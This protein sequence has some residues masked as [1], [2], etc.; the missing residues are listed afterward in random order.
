MKRAALLSLAFLLALPALH[1]A[2]LPDATPEQL[3]RW[4]GFN[5]LEKFVWRGQREKFREDDFRM[6]AGWGFNFVRLPMDYRGWIVDG[7]WNRIDDEALRDI[8]EAVTFGKKYG[9]HVCLNFHRAPGYCV[10][11]PAEPQSLW[12]NDAALA[13]CAKHW[14][15]FAKRYKGVPSRQLSFNLM[16]EPNDKVTCEK[17][18]DVVKTI[19]DAIR[20]ED[21]DRLV[22]VDAP[23][24]GRTPCPQLAELR[25]AQATRGYAPMAV[26]HYQ[27]NWIHGS[28]N[29][30]PPAW[31]TQD[32][33]GELY[34]AWKKDL[35]APLAITGALSRAKVRLTVAEV[36]S[37]A[38]FEL[39]ANGKPVWQRSF[40]PNKG[41]ADAVK[42]DDRKG[43]K[44][45]TYNRDYAVELPDGTDRIELR[46]AGGDWM[47]LSSIGIA[48][49]GG[50]EVVLGLRSQWGK[51]NA[52]IGFDGRA[53]QA[54]VSEDASTLWRNGIEPWLTLQ[55]D[56]QVGVMVGEWGAFNRTP[57][58]VTLRWM[59]DCL[60]NWERA[61]WGWAVW[62]FRG[63]FGPL[64]SGRKDVAYEE[65][66]GHQ[67]DRR[68]LE[69]LRQH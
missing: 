15:H 4:R 34:G 61:G 6:I 5:L 38:D 68:M 52:T 58:D 55:K 46:V 44:M 14:A 41:D 43:W 50:A 26:S 12:T 59:E 13:V 17:Y 63:P 11:P 48:P 56:H 36:S 65:F 25:V 24:W 23:G 31:P 18:H 62:N 53:F 66:E 7:D 45:G 1:A 42:I 20:A 22:I 27:A 47:R 67:L 10:N 40:S 60:K 21:P 69:L 37:Q 30:P 33:Y 64:D 29:M 19:T 3:P 8:D 49:A 54:P 2:E 16:N 57:H 32:V 39:L 28:E 51:R 9:I 35:Q